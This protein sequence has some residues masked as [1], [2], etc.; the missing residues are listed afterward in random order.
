MTIDAMERQPT[1]GAAN[2]SPVSRRAPT[3]QVPRTVGRV[4]DL[5]EIVLAA[6]RCNLTTAA[7][8]SGLTPTTARRHLR[9][10]EARGY[11]ERDAASRYSAGPTMLRLSAALR[12]AGPLDRL[13]AVARP[14]LDAL[15]ETTGESA[16]LA[17]SDTTV[18]TYVATAESRRAIRHVGRLGQNV[19]LDGTAVGRA[20]ASP[21][22]IAVLSGAVEPDTTAISLALPP[23]GG[24]GVAVS[25][26]GPSH[27]LK[28]RARRS[29]E[30]ALRLAVE[31][32]ASDLGA[33]AP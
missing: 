6:G 15:A 29:A 19:R 9:A 26:V 24:L 28:A 20:L 4:L 23:I 31:G 1:T 5:L 3:D 11:V 13:L 18:A 16:Y 17:V 8:R 2:G 25:I 12:D 14:R 30:Q 22:S 33:G 21:G 10:L 27:R 32:I 7:A